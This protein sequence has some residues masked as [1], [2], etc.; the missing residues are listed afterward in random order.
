MGNVSFSTEVW[1]RRDH[2]FAWRAGY[3]ARLLVLI[4]LLVAVFLTAAF[5]PAP[6]SDDHGK[7]TAEHASYDAHDTAPCD[8]GFVCFGF[9]PLQSPEGNLSEAEYLILLISLELPLRNL[10]ILLVDLPPPRAAV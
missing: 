4:T 9:I 8:G 5:L 7:T 1:P 10:S 6:G 3:A 2:V